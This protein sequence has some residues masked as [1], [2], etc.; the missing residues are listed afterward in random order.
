MF[1]VHFFSVHCT[2]VYLYFPATE[3]ITIKMIICQVNFELEVNL[4]EFCIKHS[5]E[6][7]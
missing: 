5:I 1:V 6:A 7:K 3:A 2:Y 4:F